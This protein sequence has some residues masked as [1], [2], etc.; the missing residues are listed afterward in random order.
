MR[1]WVDNLKKKGL[2]PEYNIEFLLDNAESYF[3]WERWCINH[4][5]KLGYNLFNKDKFVDMYEKDEYEYFIPI[6]EYKLNWSTMLTE[7]KKPYIF[8]T[9]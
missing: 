7:L 6:R 1:M 3:D 4:Y 9:K 8:I 2:I 5:M